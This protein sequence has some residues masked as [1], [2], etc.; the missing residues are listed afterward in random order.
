VA[1]GVGVAG[2]AGGW[3]AWRSWTVALTGAQWTTGTAML[4]GT[5]SGVDIGVRA[6]SLR[7]GWRPET[8]P[9]RAWAV[10][11]LGQIRGEP[12]GLDDGRGGTARWSAAG[13]GAGWSFAIAP[14][15]AALAA[16]EGEFLL[17]RATFS[18]DGGAELYHT[19]R[20][21]LHASLAIE[22]GWR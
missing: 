11:R 5:M 21:A 13:I 1:P 20:V 10:A 15:V 4:A 6:A 18:L 22:V 7:V 3:I 2:D 16:A 9:L 17:D 14:R 19:P 8:R 12:V